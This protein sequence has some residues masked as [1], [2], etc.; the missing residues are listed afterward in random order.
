MTDS[1]ELCCTHDIGQRVVIRVNSEMGGVVQ[2]VS[3]FFTHSPFQC[4]K[5]QFSTVQMVVAFG[6]CQCPRAIAD[7][8][9]FSVLALIKDSP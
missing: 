3:E 1:V 2:V 8:S 4:E 7:N 9:Q 6:W 5:L